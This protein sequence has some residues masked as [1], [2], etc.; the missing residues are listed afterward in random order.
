MSDDAR[1]LLRAGYAGMEF[2]V[3]EA[4]FTVGHDL[5]E[6]AADQVPGVDLEPTGRAAF[7][8]SFTIPFLTT[9]AGYG[10]LYPGGWRRFLAL[11][12]LTPK[13]EITHPVLGRFRA[14]VKHLK[15]PFTAKVRNGVIVE[16][17]WI[18]DRASLRTSVLVPTLTATP[19][20]A[21]ADADAADAALVSAGAAPQVAGPVRA[22]A[23]TLASSQSYPTTAATFAAL[24]TQ[25]A[26]ALASPGLARPTA[27][28]ALSAHAAVV[29]LERLRAT[30]LCWCELALPA[31]ARTL[32]TARPMAVWELALEVYGDVGRAAD[33]RATNS[34]VGN[35]V[36]TGTR[37]VLPP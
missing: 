33:L 20:D 10:E 29:A 25:I 17:E 19:A 35:V 14:G 37:L 7:R 11:L 18:E 3:T 4:P 21:A 28:T 8:G 6:H 23:V 30:C 2:P 1:E 16:L 9:V 24:D 27:A 13:G 32:V 26:V 15:A 34:L 5:V 22:A 36:P 31:R 12:Q